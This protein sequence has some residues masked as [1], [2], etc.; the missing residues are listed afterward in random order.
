MTKPKLSED[1]PRTE[2][3]GRGLRK[4]VATLASLTLALGILIPVFSLPSV[5]SAENL[6]DKARQLRQQAADVQASLEFVDAGIAKSAADLTLFSGMLPGAQQALTDAQGRVSAATS[7]VQSLAARVDLAQQSRDKI[8]AQIAADKEQTDASKVAIGRIAAQ[9]YKSGGVAENISMLLGT[10]LNQIAGNLSMADQ[11]LRSKYAALDKLNQQSATNLNSQ[12]RL[13]AVEAEINDLKAKADAALVAEKNA[14]DEAAAKK[15]EL[16]K[17]V[18]DTTTLSN[19]LNAKK[20][21]IQAKLA[22]VKTEQDS[23]AGQIAERQ[24]QEVLAEQ[25]RQ[26]EAAKIQGNNNWTPPPP[27]NPSAFG[28]LSPFAGAAITSGWGWRA[29]PAGTIDFNGTGAYLHTGID[30]GVSCGTPVRAPASGKVTVAGWLN[31]GGGNTV[32]LSNGVLQGNALTTVFYHNSSVAVSVGQAVSQGQVIA[33]TGNTGNST[34]CHA[35]FETW[36]NG[37]PVNPAG[38]L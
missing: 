38:L 12:A 37:S 3:K 30:Y 18:T 5:A 14:Q 10:D 36:L 13:A 2:A 15:S 16:D 20:P 28:L 4:G 9:S 21:E 22:A 34:G 19:D 8:S 17:L 25:A 29:V 11:V 26:R 32:M 33:Y 7:Q 6:D 23:V 1:K 35:H 24:R 31:N 27:G